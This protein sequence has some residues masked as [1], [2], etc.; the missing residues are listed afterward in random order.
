MFIIWGKGLILKL[1]DPHFLWK[2]ELCLAVTWKK[3]LRS[4]RKL[5]SLKFWNIA[6]WETEVP[7]S[8]Q[9]S[10]FQRALIKLEMK[11][12]TKW[13]FHAED[14]V[15][16]QLCQRVRMEWEG[17]RQ[18]GH[19]RRSWEARQRV[20]QGDQKLMTLRGSEYSRENSQLEALNILNSNQGW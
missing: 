9:K 20:G 12:S 1:N 8:K 10:S 2:E 13:R 17:P 15:D 4:L 11:D 16:F 18:W 5:R 3:R 19:C 7:K 14:R 6:E